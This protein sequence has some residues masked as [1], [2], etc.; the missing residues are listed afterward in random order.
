MQHLKNFSDY[1]QFRF[2]LKL[3][4]LYIKIFEKIEVY[5]F[6]LKKFVNFLSN[7]VRFL[8]SHSRYAQNDSIAL[9]PTSF[10]KK[11]RIFRTLGLLREMAASLKKNQKIQQLL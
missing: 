1:Q 4:L 6:R 2:G 5:D 8:E 11:S 3:K 10:L 9:S 7:L